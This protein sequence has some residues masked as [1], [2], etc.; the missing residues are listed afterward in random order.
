MI[1]N[2]T[3]HL[4]HILIF[5]RL[6]P[7]TNQKKLNGGQLSGVVKERGSA[8][9]RQHSDKHRQRH[10]TSEQLGRHEAMDLGSAM[11]ERQDWNNIPGE[12]PLPSTLVL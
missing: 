11:G 10:L 4:Q 3:R 12:C 9:E 1:Q 2:G 8:D 5:I 7:R 6:V